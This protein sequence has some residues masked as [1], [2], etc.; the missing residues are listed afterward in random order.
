MSGNAFR[1]MC[2]SEFLHYLRVREWQDLHAQLRRWS[3]SSGWCA[4][5]GCTRTG[6]LDADRLHRALLSGLLSHVGLRDTEQRDYLGA[7]GAR[8]AIWPGSALARKPPRW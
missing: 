7:R 3:S 1:R 8:F 5:A 2:R 6:R 4:P